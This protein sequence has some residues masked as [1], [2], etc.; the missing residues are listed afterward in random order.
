MKKDE[1]HLRCVCGWEIDGVKDLK[2]SW[3]RDQRVAILRCRKES[4]KL[5]EIGRI[6]IEEKEVKVIFAPMFSDWNLI[7]MGRDRQAALLK[8]LGKS[9]VKELKLEENILRIEIRGKLRES[10]AV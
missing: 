5:E 4:C 10:H 8:K 2:I 3:D 7:L 9:L 1:D 6:I